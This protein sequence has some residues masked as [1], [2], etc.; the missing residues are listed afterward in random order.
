MD[1]ETRLRLVDEFLQGG[2]ASY[3]IGAWQALGRPAD[4]GVMIILDDDG[5][6]NTD[7]DRCAVHAFWSGGHIQCDARGIREPET[8]A[9]EYGV[10]SWSLD[11]PFHPE[12]FIEAFCGDDGPFEFDQNDADTAQHLIETDPHLVRDT[13]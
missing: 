13:Q 10:A 12:A 11:G 1:A 3:A 4:G 6:P 9:D 8:M 5:E 2:C 7:D